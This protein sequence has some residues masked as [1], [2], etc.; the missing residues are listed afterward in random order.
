M[1]DRYLSDSADN[2]QTKTSNERSISTL[3]NGIYEV[4]N[5]NKHS[6]FY[7]H[8]GGNCVTGA[9]RLDQTQSYAE[10][11]NI[12]LDQALSEITYNNTFKADAKGDNVFEKVPEN[13]VYLYKK[14]FNQSPEINAYITLDL[15]NN[16]YRYQENINKFGR[17]AKDYKLDLSDVKRAANEAVKEC[18][19]KYSNTPYEFS[20]LIQ[21]TDKKLDQLNKQRDDIMRIVV[22]EPNKPAYEKLLDCSEGKLRPMQKVVDGLIEPVYYLNDPNAI[23]W[24]NEEARICEMQPNRK[25]DG[26]Q[27][28][29]GTF[30]ISGDTGE[31]SI[32]LTDEQVKKYT[33]KFKKPDK[34]SEREINEALRCEIQCVFF[35]DFSA[36]Q[37]I[38]KAVSKPKV[39]GSPKR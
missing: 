14:V 15:D 22:V 30:F 6:Y 2:F 35:E 9:L 34:F 19:I 4:I 20:E 33:E 7:T 28:I 31:D 27:A 39:K 25:F 38:E 21:R 32:S 3:N 16:V 1:N 17:K 29:C 8:H 37:N 13:E 26:K 36:A 24:A 5:D 23:I 18:N 11:M 12:S 10:Q